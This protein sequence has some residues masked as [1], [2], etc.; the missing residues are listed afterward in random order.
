MYYAYVLKSEINGHFYKG[1]TENL[2]R[3]VQEHNDGIVTYTSKFR[4]W[5]L[6]YFETFQNRGEAMKREKFFKSGK[7]REFIKTIISG[8]K[9]FSLPQADES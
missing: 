5:K 2:Y 6:V 1:S 7:G 3:R 4:P 9:G 8:S